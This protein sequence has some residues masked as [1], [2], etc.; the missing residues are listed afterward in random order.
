[1]HLKL[2][3]EMWRK[4][5]RKKGKKRR[6]VKRRCC[7]NICA[8]TKRLT[9]PGEERHIQRAPH[10]FGK[11]PF[12]LVG[13]QRG[14]KL[15]RLS[16]SQKGHLSSQIKGHLTGRMLYFNV[17]ADDQRTACFSPQQG[18]KKTQDIRSLRVIMFP[19]E[20]LR[21]AYWGSSLALMVQMWRDKKKGNVK[22]KSMQSDGKKIN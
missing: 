19:A 4:E 10:K 15:A 9:A 11:G 17:H 7:Q 2:L 12:A 8:F 16:V 14:R 18:L 22:K 21:S 6:D 20:Q 1:M 3:V 5:G 13:N